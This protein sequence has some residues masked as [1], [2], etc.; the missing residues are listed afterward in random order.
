MWMDS[1]CNTHISPKGKEGVTTYH[2][3]QKKEKGVLFV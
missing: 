2:P 3:K 1:R